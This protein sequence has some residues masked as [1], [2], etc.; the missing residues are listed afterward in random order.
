[1]AIVEISRLPEIERLPGWRGRFFHS[2]HM[3]VAH[4]EFTH[5]STIHEHQHPQ[6]EI[7]HVLEG[8]LELTV[9]GVTEVARAG[10]AAIVP[11]N[12]RHSARALTDG[13]VLIVDSPRREDVRA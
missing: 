12:A 13:R 2:E 1:M 5:G 8:E 4:Y 10:L 3:T 7:Y 9:E 11:G 6:E